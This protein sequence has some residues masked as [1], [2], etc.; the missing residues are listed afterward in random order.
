MTV[1]AICVTIQIVI[2]LEEYI[3]T[4]GKNNFGEWF[5]NLN[6]EA[7]LKVRKY[8]G[9][10]ENRNFSRV[11]AVGKGLFECKIDFGP[12][13]RVYFGK[14]GTTLVILLGGGTKKRQQNDIKRSIELWK[15]YKQRKK[16]D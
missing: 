13:Y 5:N 7:A 3:D 8:L 14:A 6:S 11:E 16:G 9:R 4:Y 12:G 10:I 2:R 1:S 15:E